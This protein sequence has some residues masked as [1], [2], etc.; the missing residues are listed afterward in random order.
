MRFKQIGELDKKIFFINDKYLLKKRNQLR[1]FDL[2]YRKMNAS[3]VPRQK[4][5]NRTESTFA[6]RWDFKSFHIHPTV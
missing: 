3:W 5:W 6:N 2:G 1:L 4:I